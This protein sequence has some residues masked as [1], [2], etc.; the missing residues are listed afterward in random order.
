LEFD[1]GFDEGAVGVVL[2]EKNDDLVL[3][4][5]RRYQELAFALWH[6]DIEWQ[7]Q[8]KKNHGDGVG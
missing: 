8:K 1:F 4:R 6:I 3:P 7:Q 5:L 2:K